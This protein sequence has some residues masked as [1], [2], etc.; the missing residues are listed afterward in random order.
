MHHAS[1][2]I[3]IAY[4]CFSKTCPNGDSYIYAL[5]DDVCLLTVRKEAVFG[6]VFTLG[7]LIYDY[8]VQVYYCG[9][10]NPLLKQI[11]FHH[12]IVFSAMTCGLIYGFGFVAVGFIGLS[13]ELSSIPLNY[14]SLYNR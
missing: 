3:Y 14:R 6:K 13:I 7:Y 12:Y 2:F 8:I 1:I 5:T 9:D 4:V 10:V 11:K